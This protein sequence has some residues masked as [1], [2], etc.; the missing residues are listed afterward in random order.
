MSPQAI[1]PALLRKPRSSPTRKSVIVV[2]IKS[3][4]RDQRFNRAKR[5]PMLFDRQASLLERVRQ[6]GVSLPR[7][8]DGIVPGLA[9]DHQADLAGDESTVATRGHLLQVRDVIVVPVAR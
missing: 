6:R 5:P 8:R 2:S 9:L 7:G 4:D 1:S 3:S